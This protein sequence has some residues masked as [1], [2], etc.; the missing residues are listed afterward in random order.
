MSKITKS[1]AIMI[2]FFIGTNAFADDG[3]VN[4]ISIPGADNTC[5]NALN[6]NNNV[7]NSPFF[8]KNPNGLC[9][10]GLSLPG[11]PNINFNGLKVNYNLDQFFCKLLKGPI[12]KSVFDL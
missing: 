12:T 5:Q 8:A 7:D 11:L 4:S 2:I 1:I 3:C 6:L 10:I 9:G